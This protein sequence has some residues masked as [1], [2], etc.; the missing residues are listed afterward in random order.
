MANFSLQNKHTIILKFC[1]QNKVVFFLL[2]CR[3]PNTSFQRL[4]SHLQMKK[5]WNLAMPLDCVV[6]KKQRF[7]SVWENCFP[8]SRKSE[9]CLMKASINITASQNSKF[10]TAAK[11]HE[12]CTL[13]GCNE[14]RPLD[15]WNKHRNAS[16]NEKVNLFIIFNTAKQAV[17]INFW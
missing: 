12:A 13:K 3:T 5:F 9:K 15:E 1:I 16:F 17:N 2:S 4:C 14:N 8:S 7:V 6:E 11:H 10:F